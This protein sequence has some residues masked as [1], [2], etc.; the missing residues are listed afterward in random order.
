[1]SLFNQLAN[2]NRP[3][4]ND[5]KLSDF[6]EEQLSSLAV[7]IEIYLQDNPTTALRPDLELFRVQLF[8]ASLTVRERERILNT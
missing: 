1:M 3:A 6:T 4:V 7:V 5:P 8:N 2:L